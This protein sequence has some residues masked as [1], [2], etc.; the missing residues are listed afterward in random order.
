[1]ERIID[2]FSEILGDY[3]PIEGGRHVRYKL[4]P[5]R[6]RAIMVMLTVEVM[7]KKTEDS[8]YR[9]EDE[10]QNLSWI[11]TNIPDVPN[12]EL[13]TDAAAVALGVEPQ[14]FTIKEP[15]G[16]AETIEKIGG[17]AFG[18]IFRGTSGTIYK[19]VRFEPKVKMIEMDN[20]I[21]MFHKELYMEA[22]IQTILQNDSSHS[23]NIA[24]LMGIFKDSRNEPRVRGEG[25]RVRKR[26]NG[27]ELSIVS[28]TTWLKWPTYFYKMESI[29]YTFPDYVRTLP[30]AEPTIPLYKL[31]YDLGLL[32]AYL[33]KSYGFRHRDLHFGNIMVADDG[34]LKLIDFGKSSIQLGGN[35]FSLDPT[36]EEFCIDLFL[37]IASLL[38]KEQPTLAGRSELRRVFTMLLTSQETGYNILEIMKASST[39]KP[40]YF[41]AYPNIIY[42]R[43]PPWN[44]PEGQI[45]LKEMQHRFNP[46][47]FADIWN[48]LSVNPIG[49]TLTFPGGGG[50]GGG[51]GGKAGGGGGSSMLP[52]GGFRRRRRNQKTRNHR[53]K[54][55]HR[56]A[57]TQTR[58]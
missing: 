3:R 34:Q 37:L 57:R 27:G 50:G 53:N 6:T 19:R 16:L 48:A 15:D 20:Q 36:P 47:T 10:S 21:E 1:M 5:A 44:S 43:S 52:G 30:Y 32:L 25:D 58:K 11:E 18:A 49:T 26:G 55:R 14:R 31:F 51:G 7:Y 9:W 39:P 40:G 54:H 12:I 35:I 23:R 2:N 22:Y 41:L 38:E 4:N 46:S 24:R 8:A 13:L 56:K 33:D 28:Q 29:A 45:I 17:G 42:A